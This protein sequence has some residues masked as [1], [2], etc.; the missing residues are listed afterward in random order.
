MPNKV[1]QQP[2]A[3]RTLAEHGLKPKNDHQFWLGIEDSRLAWALSLLLLFVSGIDPFPLSVVIILI[4]L[5]IG[6]GIG[7]V[8]FERGLGRFMGGLAA[9]LYTALVLSLLADR[10]G[11]RL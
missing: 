11:F 6:L 7:A 8:R 1:M 3:V 5:G 4:A 2:G 10:W 9:V